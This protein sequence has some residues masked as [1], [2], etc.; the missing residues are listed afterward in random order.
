MKL[1]GVQ[2]R[3][4]ASVCY[5]SGPGDG[6]DKHV[7]QQQQSSCRLREPG[8]GVYRAAWASGSARSGAVQAPRA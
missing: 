7:S 2:E 3:G 1:W 6:R 4:R 5:V 8:A